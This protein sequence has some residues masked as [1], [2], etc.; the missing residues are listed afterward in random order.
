M[1][2]NCR[3]TLVDLTTP[4]VMAIVNATPDSFFEQSR[5][6]SIDQFKKKID[7]MITEGADIIDIG[8]YSSRPNAEHISQE[9]KI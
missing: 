2:L 6:K 7:Q 5:V 3:G 1:T 9:H 8:A 4:K